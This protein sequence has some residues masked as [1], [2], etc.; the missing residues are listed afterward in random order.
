MVEL[1]FVPVKC[2]RTPLIPILIMAMYMSTNLS[3]GTLGIAHERFGD[4]ADVLEER[5]RAA[6]EEDLDSWRIRL[7]R[8]PSIDEAMNGNGSWGSGTPV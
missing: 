2:S 8:A 3:S 1:K 7:L 4:V 5:L 6:S